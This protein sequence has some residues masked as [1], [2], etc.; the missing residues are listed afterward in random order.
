MKKDDIDTLFEQ[1]RTDFDVHDTPQGHQKRFLAKLN[2]KTEAEKNVSKEKQTE[3]GNWWKPISIAATIA[4]LI[5]IGFLFQN[6]EAK[7]SDL[8]SVSPE[9]EKTQSF[10]TSAINKELQTLKSF[11]TPETKELVADALT[12]I[13]V[14][15][16][17]YE[18]LKGDLA[19]SGNDKRVIYAMITNFQ[20]RIDLLENV[21]K[22]IEEIKTLKANRNENTI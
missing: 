6:N 20:N 5:A 21:I 17:E 13:E 10:F 2:A 19:E 8:A 4:V 3:K 16:K 11:D 22:T 14:L 18:T 12:Q 1:N 9:M 15:E 7:A